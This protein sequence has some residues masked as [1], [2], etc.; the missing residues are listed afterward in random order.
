MI[1]TLEWTQSN[2]QQNKEQLQTPI[3]GSNNKQKVDNN[4]TTAL[5]RTAV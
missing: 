4:R 1:A 2:V 5:E 3:I